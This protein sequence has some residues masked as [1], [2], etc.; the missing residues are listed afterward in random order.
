MRKIIAQKLI[1]LGFAFFLSFSM[2]MA[3]KTVKG[4]VTDAADGTT[5]AGVNIVVRG[6]TIGTVSDVNGKFSL[7][8]P[9]GSTELAVS[10]VGFVTQIIKLGTSDTYE[11]ALSSAAL[12]IDE[13][14]VVGYGTQTRGKVTASIAKV[15]MKM[16]KTGVRANPAQALAG[17]VPGLRLVTA[18]G[19]PGAVPSIIL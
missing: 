3:Q 9:A 16:L 18:S 10:M 17:I 1:F 12:A 4:T 11:V 13:V 19:R 15:D 14:V 2:V 5:F 7:V 8:V 6:T